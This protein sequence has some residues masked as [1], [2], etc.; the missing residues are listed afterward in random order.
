MWIRIR[1]LWTQKFNAFN[2]HPTF[3]SIF[4]FLLFHVDVEGVRRKS[5][6]GIWQWLHEST[7]FNLRCWNQVRTIYDATWC[8]WT[9]LKFYSLPNLLMYE[10]SQ[11][12]SVDSRPFDFY[13]YNRSNHWP[14]YHIFA[15]N[16]DSMA[17][18]FLILLCSSSH[19]NDSIILCECKIWCLLLFDNAEYFISLSDK[20]LFCLHRFQNHRCG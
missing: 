13:D 4:N 10:C 20:C 8:D 5:S 2:Q 7:V 19:N 1:A 18:H 16:D 3:V 9:L 6:F 14:S 17:R 15:R 12:R 11:Q